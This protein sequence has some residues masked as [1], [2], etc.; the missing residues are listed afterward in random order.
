[1]RSMPSRVILVLADGLRLDA[2]TPER[3]AAFLR[4]F[5]VDGEPAVVALGPLAELPA[6]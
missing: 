6:S 4:E 5:P 2:V 3:V 1:M